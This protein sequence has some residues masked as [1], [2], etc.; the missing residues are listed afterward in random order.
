MAKLLNELKG[1]KNCKW[2]GEQWAVFKE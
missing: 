1:K 2:G